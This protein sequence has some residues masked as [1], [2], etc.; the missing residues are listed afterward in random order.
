MTGGIVNG[1]ELLI[2]KLVRVK[3][4][5]YICCPYSGQ[6]DTEWFEREMIVQHSGGMQVL[7]GAAQAKGKRFLFA[8]NIN[9]S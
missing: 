2:K 4:D 1:I 5:G 9:F 8:K 3:G 6:G 7:R